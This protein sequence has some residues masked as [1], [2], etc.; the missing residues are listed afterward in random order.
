MSLT[1][2]H[3]DPFRSRA[4]RGAPF[5]RDLPAR[6]STRSRWLIQHD[7]PSRPG[8]GNQQL[9]R[10]REPHRTVRARLGLS[11]RQYRQIVKSQRRRAVA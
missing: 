3:T 11:A 9:R 8:S 10:T 7:A 4:W 1:I 6:P 5:G 2:R